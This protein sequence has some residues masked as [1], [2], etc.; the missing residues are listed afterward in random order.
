MSDYILCRLSDI[1]K[2]CFIVDLNIS[3]PIHKTD[4]CIQAKIDTGCQITSIAM[5]KLVPKPD[6]DMSVYKQIAIDKGLRAALSYGVN[7]SEQFRR[8]EEY[9]YRKG[10]YS[11]CHAISFYHDIEKIDLNGYCIPMD[12][13]RVSY[14]RVK[15]VLIGMD[16]LQKLDFHCGVSRTMGDYIFLG[17][18]RNNITTEYLNALREHFGYT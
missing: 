12:K 11:K 8:N 5:R 4:S 17:C 15:S 10:N 2:N 18:L 1:Q 3:L 14:D 9:E 13:V 6:E 7:D 16:I